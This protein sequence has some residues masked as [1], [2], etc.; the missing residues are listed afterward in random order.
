MYWTSWADV[1]LHCPLGYL[2]KGISF[3]YFLSTFFLL[4]SFYTFY[5][6]PLIFYFF[7]ICSFLFILYVNPLIQFFFGQLRIPLFNEYLILFYRAPHGAAS[8]PVETHTLFFQ[9]KIPPCSVSKRIAKTLRT[10][11]NNSA[12]L[13]IEGR[14][15]CFAKFCLKV[16]SN[17][18]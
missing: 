7:L 8:A 13:I 3:T 12:P 15:T 4:P 17:I 9:L 6:R 14:F 5:P 10:K 16:T 1:I 2:D 11:Y 18:K